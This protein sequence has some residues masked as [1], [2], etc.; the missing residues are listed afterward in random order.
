MR[1]ARYVFI[2]IRYLC[3]TRVSYLWLQYN[4]LVERYLFNS[5]TLVENEKRLLI[6][7]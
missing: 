2:S 5:S 3:L 1:L 4:Y 6:L 7:K